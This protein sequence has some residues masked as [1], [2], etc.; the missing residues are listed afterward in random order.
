VLLLHAG[1]RGERDFP[2]AVFKLN[3]G[4]NKKKK[5]DKTQDFAMRSARAVSSG[6]TN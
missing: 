1:V 2:S 4:N 5:H 6:Y 3:K